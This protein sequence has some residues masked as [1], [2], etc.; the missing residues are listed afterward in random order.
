MIRESVN[1][2]LTVVR[3]RGRKGRFVVDKDTKKLKAEE[4]EKRVAPLALTYTDPT[5]DP[6]A[7]PTTKGKDGS[8]TP[9]TPGGGGSGG[10]GGKTQG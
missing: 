3:P 7:S 5:A 4:L 6:T 10:G 8:S 9:G 2:G 1:G